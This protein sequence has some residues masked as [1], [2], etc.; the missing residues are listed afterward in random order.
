[1][2]VLERKYAVVTQ[3]RGTAPDDD[4]AMLQRYSTLL[5]LPQVAAE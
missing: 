4:I 2:T 3:A 1:M 5:V